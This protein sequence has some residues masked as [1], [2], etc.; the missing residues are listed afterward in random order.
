MCHKCII[1]IFRIVYNGI[2]FTSHLTRVW[3][4]TV[5][6]GN[7]CSTQFLASTLHATLTTTSSPTCNTAIPS[8]WTISEPIADSVPVGTSYSDEHEYVNLAFEIV[9]F[10]S[11]RL[12]IHQ[13]SYLLFQT[14]HKKR[15]HNSFQVETESLLLHKI[16]KCGTKEFLQVCQ[17]PIANRCNWR[18]HTPR[19]F[20]CRLP[21][22]F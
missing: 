14:Y 5:I 15:I 2:I 6:F 17:F 21:N 9:T 22:L 19:L 20:L 1:Y 11:S 4:K 13:L 18:F 12:K 3:I 7:P 10:H 8:S 16:C